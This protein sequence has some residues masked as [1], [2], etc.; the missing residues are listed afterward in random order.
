MK[1]SLFTKKE[2]TKKEASNIIGGVRSSR[3]GGTHISTLDYVNG[4]LIDDYLSDG[5]TSGSVM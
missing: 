4:V 1:N 3:T 5:D 2:I